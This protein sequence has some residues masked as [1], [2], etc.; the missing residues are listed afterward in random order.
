M[1][2]VS[3]NKQ[4]YNSKIFFKQ[5]KG[6][7]IIYKRCEGNL[8]KI[9]K[10]ILCIAL[11]GKNKGRNLEKNKRIDKCNLLIMKCYFLQGYLLGNAVTTRRENNSRIPFSHGMGL[12]SDELYNVIILTHQLLFLKFV[13]KK[14]KC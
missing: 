10:N 3:Q 2:R 7:N 6:I 5:L 14:I 13:F 9:V 11:E 1:L 4:S 12:I 8:V